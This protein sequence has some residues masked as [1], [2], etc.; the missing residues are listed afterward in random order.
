MTLVELLTAMGIIVL[1]AAIAVPTIGTILR[2]DR[3]RGASSTVQ[4]MLTSA[5]E[6][7][8]LDG[9]A[10]GVRLIPDESNPELCRRLIYIRAASPLAPGAGT[11]GGAIVTSFTST[12][13]GTAPFFDTVE[14]DFDAA[15]EAELRE[16]QARRRITLARYGQVDVEVV[17]GEIRLGSSGPYRSFSYFVNGPLRAKRT[18]PDRLLLILDEPLALPIGPTALFSAGSLAA[19]GLSVEIARPPVPLEGADPVVLPTGIVIDLGQIPPAGAAGDLRTI[20]PAAQRLTRLTPRLSTIISRPGQ[21]M[22]YAFEVMFGPERNVIGSTAVDERVILWLRDEA[23]VLAE[24]NTGTLG[25]QTQPALSLY[26]KEI[27]ATSSDANSLVALST[28]TGRLGTYKPVLQDGKLDATNKLIN[29]D[30]YYD[31]EFYYQNII[32]DVGVND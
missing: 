15:F 14:I 1:L 5:R 13:R 27:S 29:T 21:P 4:G 7:A 17:R 32:D 31:W 24:A 26:R 11:G 18:G 6:R 10:R 25:V 3:L 16:S 22:D 20:D 28:R 12:D 2:G 23:G 8:A 9:Q 19:S 30:G